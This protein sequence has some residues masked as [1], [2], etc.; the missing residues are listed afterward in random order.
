M[1]LAPGLILSAFGG[2]KEDIGSIVSTFNWSKC[3]VRSSHSDEYLHTNLAPSYG[4]LT[5]DSVKALDENLKIM[6]AG[7]LITIGKLADKSWKSILSTMMQHELLE[8][9]H[10]EVARSDKLI[11]ESSS[12][13]K[14]DG[15][16]DALIVRE[17]K[18]WFSKLIDDEDVLNQTKIDINTLAKIV[19]QSGAA[20]DSFEAFWVKH[21]KHEQTLVD[22][23]VL[24]FPDLEHPYFKLYRIKLTAWADSSRILFHQEDRNGITGEFNS[25]KFRPRE[26][27]MRELTK[28][29]RE[30][31]RLRAESLFD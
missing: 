10:K 2:G 26:S 30:K 3:N 18:S 15:S 23:G 20:V 7:T 1:A 6:I 14:F 24:R 9:F 17:V 31:A 19:A 21:E 29:T 27:I 8:P 16:P 4:D 12:D 13:F 11:K 28:E 5:S 25:R 22:I